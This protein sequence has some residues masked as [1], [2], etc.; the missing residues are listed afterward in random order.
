MKNSFP[1]FFIIIFVLAL[2]L[3]LGCNKNSSPST[4]EPLAKSVIVLM[5]ASAVKTTGTD[6]SDIPVGSGVLNIVQALIHINDIEIEENFSHRDEQEGEHDDDD[7]DN[8][9]EN[10]NDDQDEI[11]L[12]GPFTLNISS[13]KAFIDSVNVYPGTFTKVE[14][15]FSTA[16]KQPFNGASIL[17]SGIFNRNDEQSIPFLLALAFDDEIEA[18]LESGGLT[19]EA[20]STVSVTILFD[21]INWFAGMDFSVAQISEDKIIIDNQHNNNLLSLFENNLNQ[22]IEVEKEGEDED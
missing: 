17:I 13:G 18:T 20:K 11:I 1:R 19:V 2:I 4:T 7:E 14:L 6:L 3:Q 10:E 15:E 21:L 12:K 22:N 16:K 8:E 9:S 5:K